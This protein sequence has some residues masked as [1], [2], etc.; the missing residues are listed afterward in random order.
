MS[1]GSSAVSTTAEDCSEAGSGSGTVEPEVAWAATSIVV[2]TGE[3]GT[4]L[5]ATPP[6]DP[7][8]AGELGREKFAGT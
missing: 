8:V 3:V 2:T 1:R 5:L 4:V 6:T 7:P